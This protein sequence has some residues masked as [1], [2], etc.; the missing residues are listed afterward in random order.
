M[1]KSGA[2][3]TLGG[4]ESSVSVKTCQ[5]LDFHPFRDSSLPSHDHPAALPE[6]GTSFTTPGPGGQEAG[7]YLAMRGSSS[8]MVSS[9][10]R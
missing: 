9:T 8:N 5:T 6:A 10:L 2:R 3:E 4:Q 1:E 7:Q